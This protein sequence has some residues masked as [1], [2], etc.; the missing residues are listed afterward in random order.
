MLDTGSGLLVLEGVVQRSKSADGVQHGV[1][2]YDK[3]GILKYV[4]PDNQALATMNQPP[5]L[6]PQ[7]L[8]LVKSSNSFGGRG[9]EALF[10]KLRC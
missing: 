7:M 10:L 5:N 3:T 8:F 9:S 6:N 2:G 1:F 4:A